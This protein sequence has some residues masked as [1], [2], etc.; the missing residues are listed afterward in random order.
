MEIDH[1]AGC[2]S[3]RLQLGGPKSKTY[4]VGDYV[5]N[6]SQCRPKAH[7]SSIFFSRKVWIQIIL[8]MTTIA[9]RRHLK[10]REPAGWIIYI[11]P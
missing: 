5:S 9:L 3:R 2:I 6:C 4:S 1:A 8:S 7:D 11:R 10:S